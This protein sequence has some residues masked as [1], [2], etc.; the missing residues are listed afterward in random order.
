M[1]HIFNIGD[2][3]KYAKR[4]E[5]ED[6]AQFHGNE[7]H[8]FYGTFALARDAEWSSRL[9][10]LEMKDEDEEGI[11]TF[12]YID[13]ISPGLIGQ[14]AVL[15]ATLSE[16]NGN[17]II[18]AIIARVGDR[19]IAKGKTGQKIVLKSKIEKLKNSIG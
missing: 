11:G 9:F 2:I 19:I 3:K 15:E 18:C 10:V 8:P 5:A 17:E 13:H 4:I 12:V 7:V 6:T 1:K 16:I 14:E